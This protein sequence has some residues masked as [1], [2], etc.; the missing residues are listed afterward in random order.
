[1]LL[2]TKLCYLGICFPVSV[3]NIPFWDNVG[4]Y[5][6]NYQRIRKICLHASTPCGFPHTE[7]NGLSLRC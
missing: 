3:L 4:I 1:M 7:T 2:C 5:G 6:G